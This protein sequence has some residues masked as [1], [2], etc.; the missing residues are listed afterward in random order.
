MLMASSTLPHKDDTI[1]QSL[2]LVLHL[3]E[4]LSPQ[5]RDVEIMDLK[6]PREFSALLKYSPML[7]DSLISLF[8]YPHFARSTIL[9]GNMFESVSKVAHVGLPALV[10]LPRY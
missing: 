6:L 9:K 5:E 2:T 3:L 7:R 4:P 10:E 8:G 1:H